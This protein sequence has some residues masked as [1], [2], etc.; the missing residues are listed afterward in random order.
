MKVQNRK[1]FYSEFVNTVVCSKI[2][3]VLFEIIK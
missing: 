2:K 1:E 3:R